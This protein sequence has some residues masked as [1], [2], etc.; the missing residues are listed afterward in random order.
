MNAFKLPLAVAGLVIG[1]IAVG[2][3][4]A[5]APAETPAET[6]ETSMTMPGDSKAVVA[7]SSATATQAVFNV[8]G[9]DCVSCQ[10]EISGLVKGVEGVK[11]CEVDASGVVTVQF[12]SE[13]TSP[14]K[15]VA[16]INDKTRYEASL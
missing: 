16:M 7:D 11:N 12:D 6:T 4:P 9:M 13:K 3:A 1:V 10:G 8:K 14:E 5:E 2:C 15:L